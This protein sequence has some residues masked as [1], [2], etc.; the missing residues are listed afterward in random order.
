[1]SFARARELQ[2]VEKGQGQGKE[3]LTKEKGQNY[4][5]IEKGRSK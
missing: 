3:F 4:D 1:M 5:S 2:G